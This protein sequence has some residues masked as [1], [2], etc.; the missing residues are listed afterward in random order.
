MLILHLLLLGK[1]ER[2]KK[3]SREIKFLQQSQMDG[4]LYKWTCK[5]PLKLKYDTCVHHN[6]LTFGLWI[7][8]LIFVI[9]NYFIFTA[10]V[11]LFKCASSD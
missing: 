7:F 6:L 11:L 2:H 3:R 4:Q 5:Y 8:I 10:N 9:L 1:F